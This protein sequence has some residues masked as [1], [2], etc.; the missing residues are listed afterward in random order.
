MSPQLNSHQ[1]L[2]QN[3]W[4]F[5]RTADRSCHRPPC[6]QPRRLRADNS[7]PGFSQWA[8]LTSLSWDQT[9]QS[10]AT[11]Y[12]LQSLD[13]FVD[14]PGQPHHRVR[15]AGDKEGPVFSPDIDPP[16]SPNTKGQESGFLG[17]FLLKALGSHS[18]AQSVTYEFAAAGLE[19]HLNVFL[20]A[21]ERE[22][23]RGF[24]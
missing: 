24:Y 20:S 13:A 8:H 5:R 6:L 16:G 3:E 10:S 17:S 4:T 18:P 11:T 23:E 22:R 14:W 21:Q 19:E 12:L 1:K 9:G 15:V 7:L 2:S